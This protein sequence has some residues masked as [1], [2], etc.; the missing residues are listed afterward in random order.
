MSYYPVVRYC[1]GSGPRERILWSGPDCC[2]EV[3][4]NLRGGML[5]YSD[6]IEVG[7]ELMKYTDL[8]VIVDPIDRDGKIRVTY[9]DIRKNSGFILASEERVGGLRLEHYVA[10]GSEGDLRSP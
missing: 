8:W 7:P 3:S 1:S 9:R 2:Y 6:L 4:Y 5:D 10:S